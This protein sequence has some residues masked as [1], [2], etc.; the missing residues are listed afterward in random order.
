M[1][2]SSSQVSPGQL[3]AANGSMDLVAGERWFVVQTR[4]KFERQAQTHLTQQGF[5]TFLPTVMRATRHARKVRNVQAAV[6]PGYLFIILHLQRDRW[7]AVNGTPGVSR[8]VQSD[9]APTSVPRGVVEALLL[10]RDPTGVCRFDR[11]LVEGQQV[12]IISGPM[13][14]AMGKLTRLDG[15]GRVRV[16]LELLHGP[17]LATLDRSALEA[18]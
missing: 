16:L 17:V 18:V 15:R 8:L 11:D 6:F 4:A 9:S 14:S 13:A 12:R 1:T 7:R 10:Y 2:G 5:R 3:A